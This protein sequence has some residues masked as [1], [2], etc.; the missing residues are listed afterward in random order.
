MKNYTNANPGFSKTIQVYETSDPVEADSVSNVPIEAIHDNTLWLREQLGAV[1]EVSP[2]EAAHAEKEYIIYDGDLC[3]VT[4]AISIGDSL[5]ENTNFVVTTIADE[6]EN[7]TGGGG[8]GKCDPS[9]SSVSL[10]DA[11]YTATFSVDAYGTVVARSSNTNI[12]TVSVSELNVVT[13]RGGSSPGTATITVFSTGDATHDTAVAFVT[14][15]STASAIYGA[16]WDGSS[17][18][19]WSR[20]GAAA[21]FTD[22]VPAVNNGDGSSPFDTILPWSGIEKENRGG[23]VMV[24]IPKFWYKWTQSGSS[25]KIEISSTEK[26]GFYVSP[27]HQNRGD[28]IGERDYIYVGR[29]HCASDYKSKTGV[30]PLASKT[31]AEFRTGIHGLGNTYWQ[32]DIMTHI[33]IW[34]LYLVEFAN[35]DSQKTIGYGCSVGGSA[36]ENMG[37]TDG[38]IYHTGTSAVNRTTYGHVQYRWIEDLWGNVL[39]WCDGIYFATEK[40][41]IIKNP[42]NFSDTT[43]GTYVG[44]RSTQASGYIKS[45]K[46]CTVSGFEWFMYPDDHQGASEDTYVGDHCSYDASG[47]VLYVG[48]YCGQNRHFGLFYLH[49][50]HA[51]SGSSPLIGSRLLELP[52]A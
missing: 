25:L 22:P 42:A 38:M 32:Y 28:G 45:M 46:V 16:E 14:C 21:D 8:N 50:D 20:T 17:T 15:N 6:L 1:D 44:D 51:A 31:R 39:D 13:V 12:C 36:V 4:A 41:Y 10:S 34:M 11:S 27:G 29:Y 26:A 7:G 3:R 35:W 9:V 40:M 30:A 47:V 19:V 23:N 24:K 48:G 5:V 49:G 52:A 18:Q 43:G 33:T 2:A 37:A